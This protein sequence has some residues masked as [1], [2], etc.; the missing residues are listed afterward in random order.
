MDH[1]AG[2]ELL[3]EKQRVHQR[4]HPEG[5]ATRTSKPLSFDAVRVPDPLREADIER[6]RQEAE[7][8]ERTSRRAVR[9]AEACIPDL[10]RA[11][12]ELAAKLPATHPWSRARAK[13]SGRLGKHMLAVLS[14]TYGTGKSQLACGLIEDVLDA[15]RTG[16]FLYAYELRD[17]VMDFFRAGEGRIEAALGRFLEPS[18][19]VIDEVNSSLKDEDVNYLQRVVCKRYDKMR[20]T[21]L[22]T[23]EEKD[24]FRKVVGP[25]IMDR[26]R[27]C[28]GFVTAD[29]PS[30]RA[31]TLTPAEA[32]T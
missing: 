18:L 6:R 27:E 24:E 9:L 5:V 26:V 19:L 1:Q 23:N 28:G 4:Q 32:K 22:I 2:M 10:L 17:C 15:D 14:G 8:Q 11:H 12:A 21:L 13:L 31:K 29:W 7:T 16:R 3:E 25:R 20:D 30:F